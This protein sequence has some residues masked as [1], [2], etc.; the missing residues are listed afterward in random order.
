MTIV[1]PH[2][3]HRRGA[4]RPDAGARARR[5]HRGRA[6]VP[7]QPADRPRPGPGDGRPRRAAA[8][9]LHDEPDRLRRRGRAEPARRL[10]HPAAADGAVQRADRPRLGLER[11]GAPL[12]HELPRL[13][14]GRDR[15]GRVGAARR[16]RSTPSRA[17]SSKEATTYLLV[18]TTGVRDASG[19]TLD[20]TDFLHDLNFGQTKDAHAKAYRT[21]LRGA[22]QASGEFGSAAAASLFTTQ[23]ITADMTKIQ[24]QVAASTP[25]PAEIEASFARSEVGAIAWRRQ[26]GTAVV[27]EPVRP[28]AGARR[29]PGQ[30]RQARLRRLRLAGLRDGGEG[31]PGGADDDG[32]GAAGHEPRSS[33]SSS[34]PRARSPRAAGR[35]RSSA[36]ASPT[37]SR[38][39]RGRSPRRSPT[40]GS[41]RS[42]STSS[43]TAAAPRGR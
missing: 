35:W 37:R 42:R 15:P 10:Q 36:T 3:P 39:R 30:G 7:V 8:A 23:S 16:P 34:C 41:P 27:R 31:D 17:R 5:G 12:R 6:A 19:K 24:A 25:A 38:A 4:A 33:S 29:L 26:V 28:G 21:A 14:P 1:S 32:A 9:G 22:L 2:H 11:D 40:R 18:V 20:R 13:R 43:A